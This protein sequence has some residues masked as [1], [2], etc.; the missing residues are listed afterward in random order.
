MI[1]PTNS[2]TRKAVVDTVFSRESSSNGLS[3]TR[4]VKIKM[5]HQTGKR[6]HP[7]QDHISYIYKGQGI[8]VLDGV[9]IEVKSGDNALIKARHE[10]NFINRRREE[11]VIVSAYGPPGR[12]KTVHVN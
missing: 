5:G 11:L 7:E 9:S 8:L 2:F 6:I 10:H 3:R 4:V 12:I 1:I